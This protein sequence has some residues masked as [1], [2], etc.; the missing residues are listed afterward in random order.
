MKTLLIKARNLSEKF[1]TPLGRRVGLGF[2]GV[3]L[4]V[5]GGLF[6]YTK[7]QMDREDA[8][9]QCIEQTVKPTHLKDVKFGYLGSADFRISDPAVITRYSAL[10]FRFDDSNVEADESGRLKTRI[11]QR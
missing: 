2:L 1:V 6:A 10:T 3:E 7:M 8:F 4:L 11:W 5:F 9:K